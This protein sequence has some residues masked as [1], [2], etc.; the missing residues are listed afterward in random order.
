MIDFSR[1]SELREALEALRTGDEEKVRMLTSG[2]V[3]HADVTPQHRLINRTS[4]LKILKDHLDR[5]PLNKGGM[6]LLTGEKG[7]GKSR[8]AQEVEMTVNAQMMEFFSVRCEPGIF[9]LGSMMK[10]IQRS[11]GQRSATNA[12]S[13]S[14]GT[15][16]HS[17]PEKSD[18]V[19]DSQ[20]PQLQ[21]L[22][23]DLLT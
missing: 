4:E 7:I 10:K 14:A 20:V 17:I 8:L 21:Q 19:Q 6:L 15:G 1:A 3:L 2:V 16:V 11:F 22:W 18:E 9:A 5:L 13:S 23:D 12:H